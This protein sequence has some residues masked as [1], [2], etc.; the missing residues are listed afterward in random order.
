MNS[1]RVGGWGCSGTSRPRSAKCDRLAAVVS[2][3]EST[4]RA[5]C[6]DVLLM[7][8]TTSSS[9]ADAVAAHA[10][11]RTRPTTFVAVRLQQPREERPDQLRS[12]PDRQRWPESRT[13]DIARLQS[14]SHPVAAQERPRRFLLSS[15]NYP[16]REYKPG[17]GRQAG[18]VRLSGT[19][20]RTAR[21][22]VQRA[23]VGHQPQRRPF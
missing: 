1:S 5:F 11:C 7:Y 14:C 4:R 8:A 13:G 2:V 9:E 19:S 21:V 20:N 12:L 15:S 23:N 18:V 6:G 22:V 16:V 10:T 3:S 17:L